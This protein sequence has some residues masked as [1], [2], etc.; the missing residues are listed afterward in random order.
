[1]LQEAIYKFKTSG[2]VILPDLIDNV[3]L[4]KVTSYEDYAI[5]LYDVPK[6][7]SMENVLEMLEMNADLA[8][9][10]HL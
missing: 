1:M 6:P 9:L 5:L 2:P 7:Q 10:Y 4:C 8:I 3:F